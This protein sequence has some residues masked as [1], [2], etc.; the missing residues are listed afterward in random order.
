[1]R[2]I[3]PY[4]TH[5]CDRMRPHTHTQRPH[6]CLP[7]F[8]KRKQ[9]KEQNMTGTTTP[10]KHEHALH[11]RL[12]RACKTP[13]QSSQLESMQ[14][15]TTQATMQTQRKNHAFPNTHTLTPP[16]KHR[17]VY[18]S[19]TMEDLSHT[20]THKRESKTSTCN[21]GAKDKKRKAMKENS[22][23]SVPKERREE[24][25]HAQHAKHV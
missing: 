14:S 2:N 16:A 23:V 12:E 6:I 10:T 4:I 21:F 17:M 8:E 25:N 15:A 24:T 20:H 7:P 5:T 19:P 3:F 1:M 11:T 9:T 13:H 22:H 18:C